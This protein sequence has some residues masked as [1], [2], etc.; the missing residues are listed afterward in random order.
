MNGP[1]DSQMEFVSRRL[2]LSR[3]FLLGVSASTVLG[4][5]SGQASVT[6]AVTLDGKPVASSRELN[7]TVNFY[8][9]SGSGPPAIGIIDNSGRYALKIGGAGGLE[10]GSYRVSIAIKQIIPAA[11]P[12]E[13]PRA[14]LI[15]PT[16]YSDL[17][18]TDLKAEVKPGNNSFDF[19][20]E[21][22]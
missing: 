13:M 20:L 15:S 4:C 1:S 2:Y 14:R 12:A 5:G 6:G 16:R 22:K 18:Q 7:G 9:E 19:A 21:S 3:W 17:S 10:P 11:D 8:R